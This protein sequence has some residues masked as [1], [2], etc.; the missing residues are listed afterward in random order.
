VAVLL[1]GEARKVVG[2]A[3]RQH[4]AAA[5]VPA[6][7]RMALGRRQPAA[8]V[9]PHAERGRQDACH[10]SQ[11][12]LAAQGLR[13]RMSEK[14][15]GLD[16]AVAERFVGRGKGEC[17]ALWHYAT[18]QEAREDVVEDIEMFYN[19][20]RCH[21]SLRDVSPHEYEG[22]A[23]VASLR[24]RFYLTTTIECLYTQGVATF[25]HAA[26]TA[27]RASAVS[28]Q[29]HTFVRLSRWVFL[30]AYHLPL[31]KTS[32]FRTVSN[33]RRWRS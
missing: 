8:G 27:H 32:R 25:F 31:V 18:R 30:E 24:V 20:T 17:T 23:K 6:A 28:S 11:Q 29:L 7:L 9:L 21:S 12:L 3:T 2:W 16:H 26:Y 5:L 1:D 19:S 22:L 13:W 15:A 4:V 14:G 10:A 33:R